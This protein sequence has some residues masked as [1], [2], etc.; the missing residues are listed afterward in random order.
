MNAV[1]VGFGSIGARHARV[2]EELGCKVTV[3]SRRGPVT[4]VREALDGARY[5]V[6][7]NET[8]EHRN[9]VREIAASGFEG[10]VLVEKPLFE[11]AGKIPEHRFEHAYVGYNMRFHPLT[12]QLREFAS[13]ER[14][15]TAHAYVGQ[16]L[17]TWRP[18]TDYRQSYSASR[19]RGG[20]VLR[21][22][23]HEIDTL[24]W[25]LGDLTLAGAAGGHFSALEIDSDDV[26]ALLLK[27]EK[28]PVATLQMN[29]VDRRTRRELMLVA[30][31]DTLHADYIA[32]KVDR[33]HT[34]RE[35][36]RAA[37]AG[38]DSR[39]A[40]FEDGMAVLRLIEEA[41]KSAQ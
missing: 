21:D 25:L 33:D 38:D 6:V 39:V 36:H 22:L 19:A 16:H 13:N 14:L 28:C 17:T 4:S 7:A 32:A 20:G 40:S 11:A 29:Y 2:L 12:E 27:S 26:F 8:S 15:L 23:S 41:E 31:R 34:Y 1:V 5:V 9:T 10:T 37:L 35:M 3:V 24:R 30:E 18:E